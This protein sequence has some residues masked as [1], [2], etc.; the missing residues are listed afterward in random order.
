L[1]VALCCSLPS[2]ACGAINTAAARTSS[3]WA[4]LTSDSLSHRSHLLHNLPWPLAER[5][6]IASAVLV[7]C[8]ASTLTSEQGGT[9]WSW[10]APTAG[11]R[12]SSRS[13]HQ[14]GS[15][16]STAAATK[17]AKVSYCARIECHHA[18]ASYS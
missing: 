14:A 13:S 3:S 5:S 12:S 15:L 7:Q 10:W 1:L 2:A 17:T 9:R 8:S 6:T 16:R 11:P 18:N 4:M